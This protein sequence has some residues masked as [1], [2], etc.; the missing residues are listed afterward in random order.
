[1]ARRGD[2]N[3]DKRGVRINPPTMPADEAA[4]EPVELVTILV[5]RDAQGR[6]VFG[7]QAFDWVSVLDPA[8]R[9]AL[10]QDAANALADLVAQELAA[11]GDPP[12]NLH[13]IEGGDGDGSDDAA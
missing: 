2:G 6:L 1:M 5:G 11:L 8:Q 12:D 10:L 3:D 7:A 9:L 4:D 13:V